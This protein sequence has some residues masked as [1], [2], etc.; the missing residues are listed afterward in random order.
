MEMS[1]FIQNSLGTC[2]D[3]KLDYGIFH[4]TIPFNLRCLWIHHFILHRGILKFKYASLQLKHKKIQCWYPCTLGIQQ[5]TKDQRDGSH[6]TQKGRPGLDQG[7]LCNNT[8]FRQGVKS[9]W[10]GL[11]V[12]FDGEV[13]SGWIEG[14]SRWRDFFWMEFRE[15]LLSWRVMRWIRFNVFESI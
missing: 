13:F 8:Q 7:M 14:S 3:F 15:G 6:H 2:S 1:R 11:Q 10:D 9:F 5:E 4:P 12:I